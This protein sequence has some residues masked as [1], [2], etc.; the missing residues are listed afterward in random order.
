MESSSVGSKFI[1]LRIET[2]MI[3]GLRYNLRMFGVAIDIPADVFFDNQSVVTNLSYPFLCRK[4]E[5]QLYLL[6]QGSRISY[7]CYDKI[8]MDIR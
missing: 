2:E 4:Q 1:S 5:T 8:W 6:S 7:S 3:E